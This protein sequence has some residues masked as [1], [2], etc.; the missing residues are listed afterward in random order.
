M[1]ELGT[2][3]CQFK[4]PDPVTDPY[5]VNFSPEGAS[6]LG[7][8]PDCVNDPDFVQIFSGNQEL[9]GSRPLAMAYSGHQFGSYNPRLGDGRGLLLTEIDAGHGSWD[10]YLKGCGPTRFSRGFDGRATLRSS[11]REYLAGEALHALGVPTTRALALIGIR[12][13]IYRQRPE[14]AAI[15]VR[16]SD[17]HIRFGSF[18]F[19]H[20]TNQPDKTT[21]LLDYTI[22]KQFSEFASLPDKYLLFFR[23]VIKRTATMIAL[24]Q[25]V[26]FVHGVMNTDNMSITGA[27]FDYGPF[28][29]IDRFNPHFSPNSSDHNGRYAYGQQPEI[30]H[31]NLGKLGETL[32][33]LID[34]DDLESELKNYQPVY[35][36]TLK[37]LFGRKLGLQAL[38]ESFSDLVGRMF[39]LLSKSQADFTNFFRLLAEYPEGSWQDLNNYFDDKAA[40]DEWL[41]LYKKLIDREGEDFADRNQAMNQVNPRFILRNHLLERAISK[42]LQQS[43]FS[44]VER[45]RLLC[46][47]PFDN[48]P[49]DWDETDIYFDDTPQSFVEWRLSCSA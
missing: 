24:W 12:D 20:Y 34:P 18:E 30:G 45:L 14:L 42:A 8:T 15:V 16:L 40:L 28:G 1:A 35:N 36:Q 32:T 7:L 13:L 44:E 23:E 41:N 4:S 22:E 38:D 31:W 26:G 25:S 21:R 11:I 48:A 2:D 49:G 37:E 9:P 6:L 33:H 3:F 29:F 10:V 39:N 46:L 43:D 5:L 27:T 19:F 47:N 17:S